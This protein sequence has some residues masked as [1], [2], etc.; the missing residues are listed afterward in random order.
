VGEEACK[1]ACKLAQEIGEEALEK[2]KRRTELMG[3]LLRSKG[4]FWLATS[5]DIIGGWQH[6]GNVL[7]IEPEC[8]W[9][10]LLSED[11]TKEMMIEDLVLKDM[12]NEAGEFY[13]YKDRRQEIVF[14]GHGMKRD[15]IQELLDK[16]LL[17]DEEFALGPEKWKESFGHLDEINLNREDNDEDGEE[18]EDEDEE[19]VK[20]E[21]VGEE[22][23][24]RACKFAQEGDEEDP[25]CKKSKTSK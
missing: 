21:E 1:R 13:E 23:C 20:D 2:Q 10:C 15:N 12:K 8:P 18:E 19:E 5:H 14:I 17:T 25:P 9:M 22:V 3:E 7:M 11:Q 16:C 6:A 4:F 24:K